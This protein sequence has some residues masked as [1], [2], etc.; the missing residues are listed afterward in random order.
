L[1]GQRSRWLGQDAV[2]AFHLQCPQLNPDG[3]AALQ[4]RD[5][6][7]RLGE[8]ESAGGEQQAV[9]GL[10]LPVAGGYG[11]TFHQRQPKAELRADR[12][13]R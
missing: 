6:V 13:R 8:V 9:V 12:F 11:A 10:D 4:F 2:E 7:L 5:Q 3:Q 1:F